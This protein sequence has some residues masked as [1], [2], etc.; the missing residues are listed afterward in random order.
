METTKK[1]KELKQKVAKVTKGITSY[2][3]EFFLLEIALFGEILTTPAGEMTMRNLERR[4]SR[5]LELASNPQRTRNLV[6]QARKKGWLTENLKLTKEGERKLKQIFPSYKKPSKWDGKW[7]LVIFDIPEYLKYKRDLLRERL[8]QLG[9]GRLQQSV[10]FSPYNYLEV[11]LEVVEKYHLKPYVIVSI[12]DKLGLESSRELAER[13]WKLRQIN[14]RY[15]EF[16]KK[17]LPMPG[18]PKFDLKINILSILKDDPQLP[19][20]LLPLD[21]KG[22]EAYKLYRKLS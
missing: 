20:E 17:Y 21:W 14:Q 3:I 13:V 4:I 8:K 2:L 18:I 9:F 19:K 1:R 11:I 5:R 10:W 22:G 12:T 15:K 6:F 7:Y 16:I